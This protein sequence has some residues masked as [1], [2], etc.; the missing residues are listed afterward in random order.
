MGAGRSVPW[1]D[2]ESLVSLFASV[3][4]GGRCVPIDAEGSAS[5]H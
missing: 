1:L 5:R 4:D 3:D 2:I